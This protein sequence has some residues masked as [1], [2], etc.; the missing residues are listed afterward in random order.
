VCQL[1]RL[2]LAPGV[3]LGVRHGAAVTM[4]G[5]I[6]HTHTP[7]PK[8]DARTVAPADVIAEQPKHCEDCG[9]VVINL[10]VNFPDQSRRW[11][12]AS[13]DSTRRV[14]STHTCERARATL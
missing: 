7:T 13:W 1:S 6:S 14:W 12:P 11:I 4:L 8:T 5:A 2:A 9:A 10:L 3:V